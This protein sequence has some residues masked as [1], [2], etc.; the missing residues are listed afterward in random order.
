M[1][2]ISEGKYELTLCFVLLLI[3]L[4]LLVIS[5]NN[6][7]DCLRDLDICKQNRTVMYEC[8]ENKTLEPYNQ[9][10]GWKAN[11]TFLVECGEKKCDIYEVIE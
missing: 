2:E 10:I 6:H 4:V 11:T 3:V 9:R 5:I 7:S 1:A 8:E